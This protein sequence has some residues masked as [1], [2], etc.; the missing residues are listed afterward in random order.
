MLYKALR[1]RGSK[2]Q[3]DPE[4]STKGWSLAGIAMQGVRTSRPNHL[5]LVTGISSFSWPPLTATNLRPTAIVQKQGG[6]PGTR[7]GKTRPLKKQAA[8]NS[9]SPEVERKSI[10]EAR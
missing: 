5:F 1:E 3:R 9:Y 7:G 4:N 8:P 10:W 2:V 6:N